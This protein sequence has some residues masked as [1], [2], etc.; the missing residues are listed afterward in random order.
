[1]APA[2]PHPARPLM[3]AADAPRHP[4]RSLMCAEANAFAEFDLQVE[5][6]RFLWCVACALGLLLCLWHAASGR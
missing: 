4:P 2:Q 6:R 5:L 3:L 1:M